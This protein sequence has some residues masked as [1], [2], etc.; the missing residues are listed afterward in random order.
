MPV[1]TKCGNMHYERDGR[2]VHSKMSELCATCMKESLGGLTR[3]QFTDKIVREEE[4]KRKEK[5]RSVPPK[6][7]KVLDPRIWSYEVKCFTCSRMVLTG[8]PSVEKLCPHCLAAMLMGLSDDAVME[9]ARKERERRRVY[10][11]S[12]RK[13]RKEIMKAWKEKKRAQVKFVLG[14]EEGK[15]SDEPC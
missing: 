2:T 6:V 7:P 13:R 14:V 9:Q 11:M 12:N 4:E 1:C 3:E 8:D 5:E 15:K 10:D